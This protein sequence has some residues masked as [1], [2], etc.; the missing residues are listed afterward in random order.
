M[1][2][3]ENTQNSVGQIH[4]AQASISLQY[5]LKKLFHILSSYTVICNFENF[6]AIPFQHEN[7]VSGNS[8][9]NAKI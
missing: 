3:S 8:D 1:K 6:G 9:D 2:C 7:N 5:C 4:T